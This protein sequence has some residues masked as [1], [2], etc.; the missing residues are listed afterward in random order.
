VR[1]DRVRAAARRLV[2]VPALVVLVPVAVAGFVV[3]LVLTGPVSL[4]LRGAWRPVRLSGFLVLYLVAELVGLGLSVAD[5]LGPRADLQARSYARL[6]ALL[7]F[8]CRA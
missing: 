5:L 6:G 1:A 2:T 8:L 3:C 7:D 4:L